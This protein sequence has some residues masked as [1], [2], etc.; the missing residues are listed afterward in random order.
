MIKYLTLFIL[1]L[2]CTQYPIMKK[3]NDVI[4][5]YQK[6]VNAS[7]FTD[8]D[9]HVIGYEW[10]NSNP[11]SIILYVGGFGI[12]NITSVEFINNDITIR[13]KFKLDDKTIYSGCISIKKYIIHYDQFNKIMN[14][15]MTEMRIE[16]INNRNTVTHFGNGEF[17]TM[18][19]NKFDRFNYIVNPLRKRSGKYERIVDCI[20]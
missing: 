20:P 5:L 8:S 13:H 12:D 3:N 16:T 1:F 11:D 4:R 10:N 2:N 18:A 17:G 9:Y 6:P 7:C 19:S 15:D 14:A